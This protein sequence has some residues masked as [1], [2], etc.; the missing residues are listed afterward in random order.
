MTTLIA[1]RGEAGAA[2]GVAGGTPRLLLV[3]NPNVGKS[4]VFGYLTGRYVTVSN[5]P[6]TTV[7]VSRGTMRYGGVDWEVVDTPGVN[8]LSPQSDDERVTRDLLLDARPDVI[9]QVADAKNLRRT[10]LITSELA[11]LGVPMVLV[12]NMMDE[13][14]GRGIEIDVAGIERLFGIPVVPA[15]AIDGEGLYTLFKTINKAAVPIDPLAKERS[16]LLER[17]PA[18]RELLAVE[19]GPLPAQLVVEWMQ[20]PDRNLRRGAE[21]WLRARDISW[22]LDDAPRRSRLRALAGRLDHLRQGFLDRVAAEFK[23]VTPGALAAGDDGWLRFALAALAAGLAVFLY[24][25]IGRLFGWPTPYGRVSAWLDG[26]AIPASQN[27]LA[28]HRLGGLGELLFGQLNA[29]S[30]AYESGL[31][32]PLLP[33][34]LLLIA[35]VMLPLAL[36]LK[37]S[38]RF[39][40]RLGH[41][42]RD[43]L[44]GMPV[45]L[46]VLLLMY[47]F[48]GVI[49]AATMVDALETTVFNTLLT[50]RLQAILP[51]GIFYDFFVGKYGLISV[52]FTYALAIVLPIVVTFFIAFGLLEDSGYLPRLAILSDRLFRL[53][54][55]NGKAVLPMVLGLGCDTMATM[56][57]RILSTPKERLIATLLLVLG[58]PCSAQLGVIL[59]IS[60]SLSLGAVLTV[61]GV[62]VSQMMLVGF[63]SAQLIPGRRSDFIFE[64]PPIRVPSLK[65]VWNKTRHRMWWYLREALPLFLLGTLILFVLDRVRVPTPWGTLS[66]L[67]LIENA[68]APLVTGVLQLPRQTAQVFILGFLRRDYG[69]AGLFDMVRAGTMDSV[70]IVVA[71][72]VLTLFIPCVANFFM[73]I[74][75]HGARKS[76]YM[77]AFIT[78]F[79]VLVGAVVN[80][81]LRALGIHF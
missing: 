12:L 77:L 63:L 53:M 46:I 72:I 75:E 48:V 80:W 55:L 8:S 45:L 51:A 38:R 7:E 78:P 58:V 23:T 31:L 64:V 26:A 73:M 24:T 76:F 28:G 29:E 1:G 3:G 59:G 42:S 81:A 10:L 60:G 20:T 37:R 57:T 14:R 70:Q 33:Q 68:F 69:A 47:E 61:F 30:G 79:A 43:W 21:A 65:N 11:E 39:G 16:K 9:V 18:V 13:A 27:W 2:V 74:R 71:L 19:R 34:L 52:G 36:V 15:I 40:E 17:E 44:T 49:G 62:V 25:E 50:P 54:G 56:T 67:E 32:H 41:W 6:G 35:P 4:V 66:G 5:Y 22:D